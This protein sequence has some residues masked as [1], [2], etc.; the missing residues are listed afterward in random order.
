MMPIAALRM[1]TPGTLWTPANLTIPPSLW[2]NDQ[3][4]MTDAGGG[5]CSQWND[6]SGNGYHVV[7]ATG[8]DRPTITNNVLNGRRALSF[9]AD[10]MNFPS[11]ALG[12][13]NNVAGVTTIAVYLQNTTDVTDLDRNLICIGNNASGGTRAGLKSGTGSPVNSRNKISC[14]GRRL[15]ANSFVAAVSATARTL[16]PVMALGIQNYQTDVI[17]V[18]ANG[19][20]DVQ[21]TSAWGSTGNSSATNSVRSR[22]GANTAGTAG[23]TITGYLYEAIVLIGAPPSSTEID[24]IFGYLAWHW[25]LQASLSSSHPYRYGP[26]TASLGDQIMAAAN[27]PYYNRI[28][29]DVVKQRRAA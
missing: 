19:A 20:L 11:G 23:D 7:Q 27:D 28:Y 10:H 6:I 15:D 24:K 5:A 29:R 2:L 14:G 16:T 1:R 21:V 12:I 17:S 8:A 4:S 3:S 18:W 9:A 25:G 26:P 13:A 22:I